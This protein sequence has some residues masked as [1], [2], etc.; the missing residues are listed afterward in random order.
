MLKVTYTEVKEQKIWM[1]TTY[2]GSFGTFWTLGTLWARTQNYSWSVC[3]TIRECF[4]QE[5][6]MKL[7]TG[8]PGGPGGPSGPAG[9]EIP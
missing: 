4:E 9:P 8:K 7:L 2:T 6:W 5:N 1:Q 3:H